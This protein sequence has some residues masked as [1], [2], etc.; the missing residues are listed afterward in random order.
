[1]C[2]NLYALKLIGRRLGGD[3]MT[4]GER[5]LEHYIDPKIATELSDDDVVS[6]HF[7]PKLIKMIERYGSMDGVTNEEKQELEDLYLKAF[8]CKNW[9]NSSQCNSRT[10]TW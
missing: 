10:C 8:Y 6:E 7:V 5:I 9:A 3:T 1:M 4:N 2:E